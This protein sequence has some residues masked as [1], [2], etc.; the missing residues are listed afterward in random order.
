M[1]IHSLHHAGVLLPDQVVIK[2]DAAGAS[3]PADLAPESTEDKIVTF[4]E[5]PLSHYGSSKG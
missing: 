5:N 1:M 3:D 2:R 4:K